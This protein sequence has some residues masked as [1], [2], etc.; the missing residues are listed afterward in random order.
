MILLK[1]VLVATDFSEPSAAAVAYGRELAFTYGAQLLV[2]HVAENTLT[3]GYGGGDGF[4]F[5]DPTL[6]LDLEA[7]VRRRLD[8]VI[9]DDDRGQLRAVAVVLVSNAPAQA[10]TDYAR[11]AGIDLIVA[12]THG[13][14]GVAHLLM[15]SVAERVV[16]TAPC[17][18]L[19]VRN[20]KHSFIVPDA[21]AVLATV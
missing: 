1:K 19:T 2:A 20:A 6:Q 12:G 7:D 17:P 16:R 13:R 11:E 5:T 9:S 15:G 8:Q 4:V 10:I 21:L 3:S 18:V 14:G